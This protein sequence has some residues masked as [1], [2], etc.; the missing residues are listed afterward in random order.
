MNPNLV[1]LF[2]ALGIMGIGMGI[3]FGFLILLVMILKLMS[4]VALKI[5]PT[6]PAPPSPLPVG[7]GSPRAPVNAD[8][9]DQETELL[10]VI[11]AAIARYRAK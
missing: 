8:S 6:E 5:A 7:P 9:R 1:T 11:S 3:V 10:A 2:D 4:W